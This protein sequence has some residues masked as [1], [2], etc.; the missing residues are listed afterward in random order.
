MKTFF[1]ECPREN[2]VNPLIKRN[3]NLIA[4]SIIWGAILV[5]KTM[6]L[7]GQQAIVNRWLNRVSSNSIAQL[8]II[9]WA[10]AFMIEGASGFGTPAAIASSATLGKGS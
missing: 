1:Q 6:E 2:Y 5:F 4:I 9:G 8:M 3:G 7:S 10:F